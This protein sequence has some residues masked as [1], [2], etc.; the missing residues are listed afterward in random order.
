MTRHDFHQTCRRVG[1]LRRWPDAVLL[2]VCS[3]VA[4]R[5]GVGA[6]WVR[7]A[8]ILALIWAPLTSIVLYLLAA[9]LLARHPAWRWPA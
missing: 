4:M 3:A 6:G 8:A 2:G 5:L 1:R 7:I 9:V